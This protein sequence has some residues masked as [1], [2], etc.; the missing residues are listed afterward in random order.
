MKNFVIFLCSYLYSLLG[1]CLFSGRGG[2]FVGS[3]LE[4]VVAQ[5]EFPSA[6]R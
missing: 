1:F 5:V 3:L 4:Q 2:V 6:V